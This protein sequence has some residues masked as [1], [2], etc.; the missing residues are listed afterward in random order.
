MYFLIYLFSDSHVM[1]TKPTGKC[2]NVKILGIDDFGFLLVQADGG[3]IFS[4]HPDGNSF[5]LL[6]GLIA[7]K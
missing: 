6:K 1:V 3:A 7:P 4:V 2:E 5:N